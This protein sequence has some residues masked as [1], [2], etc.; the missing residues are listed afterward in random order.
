MGRG[1][2]LSLKITGDPSGGKAAL[3]ELDGHAGL[4]GDK[5]GKVAA[6]AGGVFAVGKV[7]E[8]GKA[9]F[10]AASNLEQM[11]GSI[12]AVFGK[13]Q[14]QMF[15]F[16]ETADKTVGLSSAAYEQIASVIGSQLKNAGIPMDQLAGKTNDLVKK[17]ADMSAVFGGTA[18]DAVD[19]LSSVLK[20][21]FDPIEKY[22][23][24]LNQTTIN[25]AL[26][27]KGQS[28]LTGVALKQ[29]QVTAALDIVTKQTAQTHGQF[30]AQSGTA[31]EKSQQLSAWFDNLKATI[32]SYLLPV[33]VGL[34]DFFSTKVGPALDK[35]TSDTGPLG[36]VLGQV[37]DFVSIQLIPALS[38]LWNELAP[39]VIPIV[40]QLGHVITAIVIPAFKGAWLYVKTYL[41]PI[42]KSILGPVIEGISTYFHKASEAV[43]RNK[44]KF[45][46]IYE[47]VKPF[48]EFMRDKVA[49]VIG[50][51]LK[52]AFELLGDAIGPVVD[53]ITWILDKAGA[54]IGF[55]GKIGSFIAGSGSGGGGG[56]SRGA[57]LFGATAG[58][59]G[60]RATSSLGGSGTSPSAAVGGL[61]AVQAGDTYN[62]TVN[63]ALDP[64]AVADQI[65]RLL[66][67]R[68]RRTGT[69][70]AVAR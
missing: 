18:A 70:I 54:V 43:E 50:T 47:K 30:A 31:A 44:G 64:A 62:I 56:A 45:V 28:H 60:L 39:K 23:V 9:T 63:G 59:G 38:S 24:S 13:A 2:V 20:G 41:I 42:F 65:G 68:A 40:H 51:L 52:G 67:A 14:E 6:I 1:A 7:V 53:T 25:A 17:G 48:L 35:L 16:A 34:V 4:F 11:D 66:D 69:R 27:A 36:N 55:I 33:F 22:G 21:E 29:A 12:Q 61:T 3:N 5:L 46:A 49:P 26:A 32:G 19:A 58:G 37:A 57:S 10:D 15:Q 8:F